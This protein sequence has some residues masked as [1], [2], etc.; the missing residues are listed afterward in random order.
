MIWSEVLSYREEGLTGEAGLRPGGAGLGRLAEVPRGAEAE[1]ELRKI[2]V[3]VFL[4]DLW[5][6]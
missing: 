4:H 3:C 1:E 5:Q 2:H 6:L